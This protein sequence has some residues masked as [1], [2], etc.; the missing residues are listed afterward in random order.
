M[1]N[2]GADEMSRLRAGGEMIKLR[3]AT[4]ERIV[5]CIA[6]ARAVAALVAETKARQPDLVATS[7]E[8]TQ[9]AGSPQD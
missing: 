3:E 6:D 8:Q 4:T 1:M 7:G 2:L 5:E 9:G